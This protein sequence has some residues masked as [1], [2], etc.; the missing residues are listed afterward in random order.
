MG[1]KSKRSPRTRPM[2]PDKPAPAPKLGPPQPIVRRHLIDIQVREDG[3]VRV[4]ETRACE[5]G[6]SM[7]IGPGTHLAIPITAR[8]MMD[9]ETGG[10]VN[11]LEDCSACDMRAQQAAEQRAAEMVK[12]EQE[13]QQKPEEG[14]TPHE[15][16]PKLEEVP[17]LEEVAEAQ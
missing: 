5:H 12:A 8:I 13:K 7:T 16:P 4:E 17:P 15:E 1:N 14:G 6:Q 9:P 11:Y 3:R 10:V 2:K